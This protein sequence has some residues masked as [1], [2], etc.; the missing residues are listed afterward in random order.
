[1]QFSNSYV[2]IPEVENKGLYCS[3]IIKLSYEVAYKEKQHSLSVLNIE[4]RC[5]MPLKRVS[6]LESH[7]ITIIM[8]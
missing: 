1:M 3:L 7:C 8:V 4:D 2:T 6:G 5:A